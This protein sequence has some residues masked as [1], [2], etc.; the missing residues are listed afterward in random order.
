MTEQRILFMSESNMLL[1]LFEE[2]LDNEMYEIEVLDCE[3]KG[4]ESVEQLHPD[5]ILLDVEEEQQKRWDFL[6]VVK[7]HDATANI[8]V[9]LCT[10]ASQE[11]QEQERNFQML[12]IQLLYKPFNK[13][14]LLT[15]LRQIVQPFSSAA[16]VADAHNRNISMLKSVANR[17]SALAQKILPGWTPSFVA[18]AKQRFDEAALQ[19]S[20][21]Q[22]R[23]DL[24]EV[25]KGQEPER[26][27]QLEPIGKQEE[28]L[29]A[30]EEGQK[31]ENL[32]EQ[33]DRLEE[34][35]EKE[36]EDQQEQE[37]GGLPVQGDQTEVKPE[38]DVEEQQEPEKENL[39]VLEEPPRELLSV[40]R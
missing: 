6:D 15:A 39:P 10:D 26:D 25:E 13:E 8:P 3:I 9:L 33:I 36:T 12:N 29:A 31:L 16:E 28:L 14:D 7:H 35:Q 1:R 17:L 32:L 37:Q 2:N 11:L 24:L 38:K 21:L 40:A 20:R 19:D 23:T 18:W 27:D 22:K 5:L 4:A 30:S 34:A